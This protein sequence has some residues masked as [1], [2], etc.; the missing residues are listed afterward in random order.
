MIIITIKYINIR[1]GLF[2]FH[3]KLLNCWAQKFNYFRNFK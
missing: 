1:L 3:V 2:F